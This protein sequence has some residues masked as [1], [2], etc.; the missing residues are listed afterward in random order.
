MEFI[1]DDVEIDLGSYRET[2]MPMIEKDIQSDII[3]RLWQKD[4]SLFRE[5]KGIKIGWL[6]LPVDMKGDVDE[7]D[8]FREE[9]LKKGIKNIL[10]IGMG[11]SS[12]APK[13]FMEV[14]SN[15]PPYPPLKVLDTSHPDT[16]REE[17]IRLNL[18][19]TLVIVSSKSGT[20][21]ETVS[22]F[23]YLYHKIKEQKKNVGQNFIAIT[24][25]GTPLE[26]IARQ[27]GFLKIFNSP[28]DVGGRYS[29]FTYFGL[30]PAALIGIDIKRLLQKG[31][32]LRSKCL[33]KGDFHNNSCLI[34]G[35]TIA[36]LSEI[37]IDKLTFIAPESIRPFLI[38]LEQLIAES[39]GKQ[40]K[41]ILPLLDKMPKSLAYY[42]KDRLFVVIDYKK[43]KGEGQFQPL[44]KG[45]K[46]KGF[47]LIQIQL[48]N[49]WD[50]GREFFRWEMITAISG[51]ILG[52][53][54]FDQP[55]VDIAKKNARKIMED[56]KRDMQWEEDSLILRD[57]E[58]MIYGDSRY[59]NR[60]LKGIIQ[61][62]LKEKKN[63]DYIS[64]MA[65]LAEGAETEKQMER[66]A[67]TLELKC[68]LPVTFNFGP[69][70]LH[71][72]GQFHKGGPDKGIFVMFLHVSEEEIPVPEMGYSFRNL[73]IS[74]C[75]GDYKALVERG[76]KALLIWIKNGLSNFLD[77]LERELGIKR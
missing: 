53:N 1:F 50:L 19:D 37:G 25:P 51:I 4:P 30:V 77:R 54:P 58:M 27:R 65:F 29:V 31:E 55:N 2:L 57:K 71:S 74:Q 16:I 6:D 64:I 15:S 14:F 32:E 56:I 45:L 22:L 12:L 61:D 24:D 73:V 66:I 42:G 76:K 17:L 18:K 36:H 11:G 43:G 5:K 38:W 49:H 7:I 33:A 63:G 46:E 75:L 28:E 48:N 8:A 68:N 44:I 39:T 40:G 47:P 34:L 21:I 26:E 3:P 9:I 41:G 23:Y 67:E 20:T 60:T 62:I 13:L 59:G 35:S 10:L 69:R 70:Y 52:V 72:T